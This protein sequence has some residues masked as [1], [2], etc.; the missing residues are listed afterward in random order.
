MHNVPK[1][2]GRAESIILPF[3][4]FC[5]W[6]PQSGSISESTRTIRSENKPITV[7]PSWMP[8]VQLRIE[9]IERATFRTEA[10]RTVVGS[11]QLRGMLNF[12][13]GWLN[14]L[15]GLQIDLGSPACR[16]S[17]SAEVLH[18]PRSKE[19]SR[20]IGLSA[21]GDRLELQT[22][23]LAP[24]CL[25]LTGGIS[26]RSQLICFQQI[27]NRTESNPG[28]PNRPMSEPSRTE[29]RVSIR[30]GASLALVERTFLPSQE[31][32]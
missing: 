6:T 10:T 26:N 20:F 24:P 15:H 28:I 29:S 7:E 18:A 30:T 31:V 13:F 21:A 16:T 8:G 9:Q 4:G 23:G 12:C 11:G 3:D 5:G 25:L 14:L 2:V 22:S 19:C 1:A 17:V 27:S 32:V